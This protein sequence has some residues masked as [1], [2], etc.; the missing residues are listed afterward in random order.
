MKM[1]WAASTAVVILTLISRPICNT[2]RSRLHHAVETFASM[3]LDDLQLYR[4][5][6]RLHPGFAAAFVALQDPNLAAIEPGRYAVDGDRLSLIIGKDD[7]RGHEGAKLEAHRRY[8]DIQFVIAGNEEMGW[9]SLS[10][11]H[12]VTKAYSEDEDLMFFGD[13]A[14]SWFSVP[15]GKFAIFFPDDA[16]APLAGR[17]ELHKAVMKIAVDW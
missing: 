17:G 12:D 4:R 15:P 1:N 13:A 7:G 8:I 10:E 6:E 11:C 9:R 5:Y 16:H 14:E 3:I 2:G